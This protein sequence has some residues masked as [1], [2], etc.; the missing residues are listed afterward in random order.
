VSRAAGLERRGD[1]THELGLGLRDH[2]TM[3]SRTAGES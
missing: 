1:D 3:L 2:G